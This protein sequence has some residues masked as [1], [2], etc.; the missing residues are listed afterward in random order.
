M[1]QIKPAVENVAVTGIAEFW[2]TIR[3]NFPVV[4]ATGR[5]ARALINQPAMLFGDEPT[6]AL[7][8]LSSHHFDLFS[9]TNR[10]FHL[11]GYAWSFFRQLLPTH[12]FINDGR[13]GQN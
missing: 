8:Q 12:L 7:T 4:K 13:I 3:M 2:P 5:C 10:P 11:A 1:K 9:K 6:G